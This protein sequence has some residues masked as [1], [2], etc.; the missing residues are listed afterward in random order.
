M[1]FASQSLATADIQAIEFN[2]KQCITQA[3][4]MLVY[5]YIYKRRHIIG[6]ISTSIQ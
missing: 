5:T 1:Q 2:P 3:S 6:S 4:S